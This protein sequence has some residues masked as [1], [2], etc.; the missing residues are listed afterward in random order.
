MF[1]EKLKKIKDTCF[2]CVHTYFHTLLA[3]QFR[4]NIYERKMLN[5]IM[6][7][8]VFTEEIGRGQSAFYRSLA[9]SRLR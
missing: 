2:V 6:Y 7:E 1:M 5:A 9:G 8:E 3:E 4:D